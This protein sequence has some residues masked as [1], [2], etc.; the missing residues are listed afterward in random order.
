[1]ND[2]IK[3]NNL[4]KKYGSKVV[5]HNLTFSL[6]RNRIVGLLG[7]N[8]IGKT[9]LLRIIANLV[10]PTE[11][12]VQINNEKVSFLLEPIHFYSFMKVKDA[13]GYYKDF[14]RD[15][16]CLKAKKLCQDFE[17]EES[18]FIRKLSKG[19][20]EKLCLLLNLCRKV[21]IYLLD[22]PVAGFDPKL[23]KDI[24]K[25]ILSNIEED[26]TVV[27]STH[28]LKDLE[29]IFD[30]IVIMQKDQVVLATADDIRAEGKTVE[31]YYWEVIENEN[32][33]VGI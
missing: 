19:N 8:G 24:K 30:E 28:L 16:D 18:D 11:G 5:F 17:L 4:C 31:E 1:M 2:L 26:S 29:T 9:T 14:Y 10:K 13:I 3:V 21:S 6:S 25:I 22:E 32:I 20:R 7:P 33:E 23:K 27:I 15:F 12:N